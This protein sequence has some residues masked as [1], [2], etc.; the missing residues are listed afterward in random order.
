[1]GLKDEILENE[2]YIKDN[3]VFEKKLKQK[4]DRII[5]LTLL[6]TKLKVENLKDNYKKRRREYLGKTEY[7]E[8]ENIIS[9]RIY[10]INEVID[11]INEDIEE[12]EKEN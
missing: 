7:L 9:N 12:L 11:I 2:N 4:I 1:M 5:K 6:R 8:K 10:G 3:K